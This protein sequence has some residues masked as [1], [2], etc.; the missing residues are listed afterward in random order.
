MDS[1]GDCLPS[2]LEH[3]DVSHVGKN[4]RVRLVNPRYSRGIPVDSHAVVFCSENKQRG[5][6]EV[7]VGKPIYRISSGAPAL[8]L[9]TGRTRPDD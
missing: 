8:G 2:R 7:R 9:Q 5:F 3:H 4:L 1:L 6:H